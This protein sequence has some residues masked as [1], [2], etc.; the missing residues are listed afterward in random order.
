MVTD[1]AGF[2]LWKIVLP[3]IFQAGKRVC[4]Y[5][6][7]KRNLICEKKLAKAGGKSASNSHLSLAFKK[8]MINDM[9][10][11]Y[12]P[13]YIGPHVSSS[14]INLSVLW[15]YRKSCHNSLHCK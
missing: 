4:K 7:S 14:F 13:V 12:R 5:A 9:I 1:V 8:N 11:L 2:L 10:L 6:G 3:A 15:E